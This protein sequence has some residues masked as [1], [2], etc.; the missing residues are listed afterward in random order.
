MLNFFLSPFIFSVFHFYIFLFFAMM[1]RNIIFI[2]CL[3]LSSC[4]GDK[5]LSKIVREV[6]ERG[7]ENIG[8]TKLIV[9]NLI[10]LNFSLYLTQ[11]FGSRLPFRILLVLF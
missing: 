9:K 1:L 10:I 6:Y 5:K 2:S 7:R 11:T 8:K 4:L 3:V